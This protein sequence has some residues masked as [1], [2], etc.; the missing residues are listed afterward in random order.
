MNKKNHRQEKRSKHI[1]PSLRVEREGQVSQED[2]SPVMG[3][4]LTWD[5]HVGQRQSVPSVQEELGEPSKKVLQTYW[6]M[7]ATWDKDRV[8]HA[9]VP[10]ENQVTKF[11]LPDL[12]HNETIPPRKEE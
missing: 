7:Q 3:R 12:G 1:K 8:S 11:D 4:D 5:T 10:D 6:M 2:H 9:C